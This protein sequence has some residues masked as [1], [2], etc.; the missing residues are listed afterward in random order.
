MAHVPKKFRSA[1]GCCICN[2]KSSSS[3]FTDTKPYKP[4]FRGCFLLEEEPKTELICNACVLH[5]KR[6]KK[7]PP[8]ST[9]D[10]AYVVGSKGGRGVKKSLRT[11][12]K[13]AEEDLHQPII[14]KYKHKRPQTLK[15][16]NSTATRSAHRN[17]PSPQTGE[18]HLSH[19]PDIQN[20]LSGT[21]AARKN[22]RKG[23]PQKC[24][25]PKQ[26]P[27]YWTQD[28]ICCGV[29]FR[30]MNGEVA[31]DDS[32][33]HP[34]EN[35]KNSRLNG[36]SQ[37]ILNESTE[38]SVSAASPSISNVSK[39]SVS[40]EALED[41]DDLTDTDAASSSESN[42]TISPVPEEDDSV[43]LTG[44]SEASSSD[45]TKS[46]VSQEAMEDV[47][48]LSGADATSPS[49]SNGTT[50]QV[51][52]KNDAIDLTGANAIIQAHEILHK[53]SYNGGRHIDTN[54]SRG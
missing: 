15:S 23:V 7:E 45:G 19:N 54:N 8:G 12:K 14:G 42:R 32:L 5:V 28:R 46:P 17:G 27:T 1:E 3:R 34:C 6:F 52:N 9:K 16:S 11:I 2:T 18:N 39:S 10:W 33:L 22:S 26:D 29:I 44:P 49:R 24:H 31:I 21:K 35:H 20:S 38:S 50:S 40:E 13:E 48:D 25:L 43:D 30:G 4:Y 41:D 36:N 47:D 53:S 37:T 51:S